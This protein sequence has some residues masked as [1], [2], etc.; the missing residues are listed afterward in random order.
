M[1]P[2]ELGVGSELPPMQWAERITPS[3]PM[4]AALSTVGFHITHWMHRTPT[5]NPPEV[6]FNLRYT[7]IYLK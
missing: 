2:T 3:H 4:L 5:E 1:P 6:V 7:I